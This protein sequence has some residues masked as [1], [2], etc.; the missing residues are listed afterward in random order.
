MN[1]SFICTVSGWPQVN[2]KQFVSKRPCFS[3]RGINIIRPNFLLPFEFFNLNSMCPCFYT[4]GFRNKRFGSLKTIKQTH[5]PRSKNSGKLERPHLGKLRCPSRVEDGVSLRQVSVN[6]L[7]SFQR[8]FGFLSVLLVKIFCWPRLWT[9]GWRVS[10]HTVRLSSSYSLTHTKA[11]LKTA[12]RTEKL[13]TDNE[14]IL[15]G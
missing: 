3:C 5:N 13:R 12:S 9:I 6:M 4:T 1:C 15:G 10:L 14:Q 7:P 2:N 8:L 11:F